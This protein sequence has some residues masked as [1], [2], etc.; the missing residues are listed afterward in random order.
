V[1]LAHFFGKPSPVESWTRNVPRQAGPVCNV[2]CFHS[3]GYCS[4][5][6]IRD[7]SNPIVPPSNLRNLSMLTLNELSRSA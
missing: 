4:S 5:G 1:H 6:L 7:C 2:V 3:L